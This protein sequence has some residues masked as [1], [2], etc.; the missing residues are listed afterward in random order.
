MTGVSKV[1]GKMCLH[2]QRITCARNEQPREKYK[3]KQMSLFFFVYE[4]AKC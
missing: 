2:Q 3:S 1:Q 4:L